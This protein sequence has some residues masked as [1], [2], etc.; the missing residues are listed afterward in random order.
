MGP[1]HAARRDADIQ[2]RFMGVQLIPPCMD[3]RSAKTPIVDG[4]HG[5]TYTSITNTRLWPCRLVDRPRAPR[6]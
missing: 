4:L 3:A 6:L 5:K 2:V 1:R